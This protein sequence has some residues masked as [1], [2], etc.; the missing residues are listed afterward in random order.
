MRRHSA[1]HVCPT[2]KISQ[3]G[4]PRC[5]A[6]QKADRSE[7]GLLAPRV[8]RHGATKQEVDLLILTVK[9]AT[10][11]AWKSPCPQGVGALAPTIYYNLE[12]SLVD[13]A[14]DF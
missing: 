2:P 14:P 5:A 3:A 4:R 9:T 7:V 10:W 12:E 11:A 1:R 8:A 13:A 6:Y